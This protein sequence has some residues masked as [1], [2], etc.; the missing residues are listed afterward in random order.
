MQRTIEKLAQDRR[1][2]EDQ[3]RDALAELRRLIDSLDHP[4]SASATLPATSP[5]GIFRRSS[6]LDA[7]ESS[8]ST[9][10]LK[11]LI[12]TVARL[13]ET[14]DVLSDV[15]DKL[16]D[17]EGNNHVGMIFK[18]MEW[19]I[20]RLAAAYEDASTLMRTFTH[21]KEQLERLLT[22]V[23]GRKLP[24]SARV[25][26]ILQPLED[27]RYLRFE[28]RFRGAED[29]IRRHQA[30]FLA[31]FAPGSRVLDL[32]CGRGEFLELLGRGGFQA[33]GIDLNAEMIEVCRD[34]GLAVEQGDLLD[35]LAAR[36]DASLDGIFSSQVIEHLEPVALRRLIELAYVKLRPNGRLV[37]E[38]VNPTSVFA[39][40]RIYFLDFT[41]RTPVHPQTLHFLLE[42]AGFT[43]VSIRYGRELDEEKLQAIPPTDETSMTINRNWDRLNHL[44][45]GPA[46]YAVVGRKL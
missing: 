28:N 14:L 12:E 38:T 39:L 36:P 35:L 11:T 40:V 4:P 3:L 9:S 22:E 32:G 5:Q 20:D 29:E 41:H 1:T 2:A 13:V 30:D 33:E 16:W 37:L 17:A 10:G 18:S 46:D 23:E 26:A 21:L 34:K 19:R 25:E 45:Y 24:S 6:T 27:W 31:D 44:L 7:E 8:E 15:R 43:S 42:A